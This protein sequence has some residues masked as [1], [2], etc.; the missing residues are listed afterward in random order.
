MFTYTW[1]LDIDISK[2]GF[3][4]LQFC[5]QKKNNGLIEHCKIIFTFKINNNCKFLQNCLFN[6]LMN[7]NINIQLLLIKSVPIIMLFF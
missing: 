6:N 4:L 7:K 3:E 5:N 2:I 1:V